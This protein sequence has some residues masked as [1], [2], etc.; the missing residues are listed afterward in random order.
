MS[1][2]L[3]HLRDRPLPASADTVIIGS[4]IAGVSAALA[5]EA[6][7]ESVLVLD[8]HRPGW[9]ASGRNAGFL[10]RGAADNYAAAVRDLGRDDARFL[11]RLT[12]RNLEKLRSLGVPTLPCY[13][14]RP[15]CLIAYEED[16]DAELRRSVAL[17]REDGFETDAMES[18]DFDDTLRRDPPRSGLINPND[19]VCDPVELLGFLSQQLSSII[20]SDT[21]V[22]DLD[23]DGAGVTVETDRGGI[24]AERVLVCTNA[25]TA[26]LLPELGRAIEPN[27][28]QMLAFDASDLNASD[29]LRYAYY[30]NHGSE[31][32][33]CA[34]PQ[35]IIFGGWRK[36]FADEER[37]LDTDTSTGV[38]SGLERFAHRV[39]GREL[40]VVHRWA[41]TMGFTPDG[42]PLAG[43]AFRGDSRVWICAGFTGHGMSMAHETANLVIEAM[44]GGQQLPSIFDPQRFSIGE[45][46]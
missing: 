15:S 23:H 19:A 33:R 1:K 20:S 41:G 40:K 24:R 11:W 36:H 14:D 38:Q 43:T 39:M 30:A 10:M 21:M 12:E 3:W 9:G 32:F 8:A 28:G 45:S 16:E 25:Y 46:G 17:L 37:T 27:R 29:G 4:G 7:G 18:G 44:M 13:Q 2:S 42:L 22:I 6:R 35:T 5:L 34:D 31:Y 26:S